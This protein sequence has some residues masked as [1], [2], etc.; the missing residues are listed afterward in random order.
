M[1][2]NSVVGS[3][4]DPLADKVISCQNP[5]ALGDWQFSIVGFLVHRDLLGGWICLI[6]VTHNSYRF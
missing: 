3:Y 5:V 1:G 6:V 2:I 4:L